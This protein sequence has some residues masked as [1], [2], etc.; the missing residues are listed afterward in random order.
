MFGE[1]RGINGLRGMGEDGAL[2]GRTG[3]SSRWSVA[4]RKLDT[5]PVSNPSSFGY[6]FGLSS[7]VGLRNRSSAP[8][9]SATANNGSSGSDMDIA[10]DSDDETLNRKLSPDSSPQDHKI[11][12][13]LFNKH[14]VMAQN[15]P[16]G[17]RHDGTKVCGADELSDSAT[18]TEV[19]YEAEN[20][21]MRNNGSSYHDFHS[22]SL[23]DRTKVE[24]SS[25][26]LPPCLPNFHASEQGPWSAM[27]AFEACLR[28]CLHSSAAAYGVN[29]ASY[30]LNNECTLLRN[31]F[32]LQKY[33]LQSEEELLGKGPSG[34]VTETTTAPKSKKT[35][36]KIKLQV[37]RIKMGLDPPP[38]CSISSMKLSKEK[39]EI[40]RQHIADLNSTL[41][42]GWKAVKRVHVTPQVPLNGS[43]S[44]QSLA[45]LQA[46]ARYV[47]QVSK[48]LKNE[49]VTSHTGPQNYEAVQETYSCLL[50]LKSSAEEDQIKTQPGSGET[51][52]FLPD[53]LGDDL[54]LEV[55]DSKRQYCGRVLAQLAAI[56]DDPSEKL[57]WWPIY[58]EPEHELI[59]RIQLHITYSTSLDE[60]GQTKCGLVAETS[61][62]DLVL[63]VAMK[64]E[65]FQRRNLL[66]KG[67]WQW[68]VTRFASYY[69]VSDV[70]T[71][72]RYLS[73]VMDVATPTKDC[74]DLIHDF[75]LPVL[76]KDNYKSLLSHQ[77]NR[78][79]GEIDEQIQQILALA[80]ENYKS[81]DESSLSGIKDVF[82]P[83]MGR[84]AP[85][86][87][88]AVKLYGLLNDV[89][90]PEA[91]LRLCK[92]FQTATKKRSRTHLLETED[93]LHSRREGAQVDPALLPTSYQKMK[94][95][96][97][98]FKNE[99]HTDIEIHNCNV[100]PS[101]I[102][103]R[104]I[105]AAIYS[106]DLCNRLQGFLLAWPP[107]GPSP[108]V[109]DLVITTADFQTD[110]SC[111]K[112]NPIKGGVNAKE[113]FHSYITTW[114]EEKKRALY[115]Y[116]KLE[117]VKPCS[118]IPDFTSP[119][120]DEMYQRLNETLDEYNIIIR[121]WPEYA[122]PLE[123]VA[124]DAEKAIVEA[125]EKQFAE[126]L[127]PLRENKIFG[128]KYVQKLTK[129]TIT[130]YCVPKELGV[131]LN[132]VKRMLDILR[133][134]VEKR[135]KYWNS[136]F[137]DGEHRVLGERLSEVTVLLRAKFRSY[138]QALV[139]KLAENTRIQ[140]QMRIKNIIRDLRETTEESEVRGRMKGLE[141]LIEKT[142]EQLHGVFVADV[143]VSVC[144]GIWDRL[145]QDVLRLMEDKKDNVT[146][147][148][149]P[150][151]A[152]SVMDEIFGR[153]MQEMM[154]NG[155]KA[156]HLEPPRS[157]M[158]L[159]SMLL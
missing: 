141:D 68:M 67:P 105:S 123:K 88:P 136:Y 80:F 152:I 21:G 139:E 51:F 92:Y 158:D 145:G 41:S 102:D 150:R 122:L 100:L 83:A 46:G 124:V 95:L 56:V 20:C 63:E 146:W 11:S 73:Y 151:I 52:I 99:I 110:I 66:L 147:H 64:A 74:L 19:S 47:K 6:G 40:V 90:I 1:S 26:S 109:V 17:L 27:I 89:L 85:A 134:S 49:I 140:S 144:R 101:F 25:T 131:L 81:L 34:L 132:S 30:F 10:S 59:G 114:I 130:P 106:V 156:E 75:L 70:Y 137:P 127:S 69:G 54:I 104:N 28:L 103:L 29:E 4:T 72:L 55:R 117:S 43:I 120:V 13:G 112:I 121:R 119:F 125:L 98:S 2:R 93:L 91:Q 62:Y 42:S 129:G 78:M 8:P 138:M 116:C 50:R 12:V 35:V 154:G 84:P 33:F 155:I 65:H 157:V 97:L 60:N 15:G 22:Q 142:I 23:Y 96:I 79:M 94:S 36:G 126:V 44:R 39:L 159:R 32:G 143:F 148:K 9:P 18:S 57:R 118:E 113:L 86:L 133:P 31:A 3:S 48:V 135:F 16:E 108:P 7:F 14:P 128:L 76:M 115:E 87:R 45:Y 107:P 38:G 149:G 58:H 111:W 24:S 53:S 82:E 5:K 153:E 61:A 37:R 71:R 77:E